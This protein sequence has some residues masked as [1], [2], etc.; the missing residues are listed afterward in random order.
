M[1]ILLDTQIIIWA[2]VEPDKVPR[3]LATLLE[4][5][6]NEI[7]YSPISAWEM[8]VLIEKGRI[9]VKGDAVAWTERALEGLRE[10]PLNK[11][12]A[13]QSRRIEV[14]HNDPA[15]RFI[16]ATAQVYNL[17][18]ATSDAHLLRTPGLRVFRN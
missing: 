14:P 9:R 4:N 15:D 5:E 10:A 11:N 7:W 16:A 3:A 6:A 18:L 17:V 13:L 12:V 2:Q 1:K 8:L